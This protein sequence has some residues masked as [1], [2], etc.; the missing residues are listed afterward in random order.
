MRLTTLLITAILALSGCAGHAEHEV[1]QPVPTG[2]GSAHSAA[3]V[4][5]VLAA[6]RGERIVTVG[7]PADF[8]PK[9]PS[10]A[11]RMIMD[12]SSGKAK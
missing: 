6:R 4:E 3:P 2:H 5:P 7:V 8:V 1:A 9:A 10:G 12:I 11:T